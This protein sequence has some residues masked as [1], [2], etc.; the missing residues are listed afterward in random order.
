M[1][2]LMSLYNHTNTAVTLRYIG[3]EQEKRMSFFV[4]FLIYDGRKKWKMKMR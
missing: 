3:H 1:E 4:Q 2:T